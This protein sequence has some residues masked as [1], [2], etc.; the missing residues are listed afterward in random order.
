[1]IRVFFYK[2]NNFMSLLFA[3]KKYNL[4]DTLFLIE[5]PQGKEIL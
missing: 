1:M 2:T 3:I 5:H 4:L